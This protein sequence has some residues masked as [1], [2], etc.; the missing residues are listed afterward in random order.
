MAFYLVMENGT[1]EVFFLGVI[2]R[3]KQFAVTK[4]LFV[5]AILEHED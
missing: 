2:I 4:L 1:R 3:E 5:N